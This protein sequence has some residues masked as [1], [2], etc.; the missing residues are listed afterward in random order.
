MSR[1]DATGIADATRLTDYSIGARQTISVPRGSAGPNWNDPPRRWALDSMLSRPCPRLVVARR[2]D[3]IVGH[4]Q[5]Q[6][7]SV[8]R[9]DGHD[10]IDAARL[11]VPRDVAQRLAERREQVA[12]QRLGCQ[13]V[14]LSLEQHGRLEPQLTRALR[15]QAEHLLPHTAG[16][17]LRRRL[18]PEDRRTDVLHR[19]IEIVH[20]GVHPQHRRLGITTDQPRGPLQ[21]ETR[22][23]QPLHDRVV[24]I[25]GDALAV[26]HQ[27]QLLQ[28][29][30]QPGILD[31]H[32][33]RGRQADH[34]LLVDVGEHLGRGL[35]GQV[36]VAEHLVANPDRHAEERVH[37]RVVWGKAEAVGVFP[38]VGQAQRLGVDDQQSED[39]VT[40]RQVADG[41][42]GLVVDAHGDELRQAGPRSSRTPSAP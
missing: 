20:G 22:G 1:A 21:R 18:E 8:A 26:L 16:R 14:D 17:P 3:A 6:L 40:L 9:V 34:E 42:V 30:V 12:G 39:A 32:P 33:R 7:C 24:E 19:Q 25:A 37:R 31:R 5:H 28:P 13:R 4:P 11:S 27:R 15:Q 36:E 29:G 35:V 23:E 38:Q 2:P 41:A 10:H